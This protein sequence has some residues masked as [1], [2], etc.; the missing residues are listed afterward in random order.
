MLAALDRFFFR[1]VRATPLAL[2]RIGVGFLTFVWAV[3]LLPDI[4]PLLTAMRA[5]PEGDV[6]WWQLWPQ[7]PPAVTLA[8]GL[9]LI[10]SAGLLTVGLWTRAAAWTAFITCLALQ[11]Y[12]PAAFNGGDWILRCVLLP[13]LALAPAGAYLS[14]DR[15]RREGRWNWEAPLVV[16]WA[17][18]FVQL[19][20]S[21]GYILTVV[22]KLRGHSWPGGTALWNA[23]NLADL[24]RFEVPYWIIAPPVGAVLT[25]L[26]LTFELGVGVGV[27]FRRLRPWALLGGVALHLGIA[28]TM[29]ITL[30]SFIMIS[31][32]LAFLPAVDDVRRLLLFRRLVPAKAGAA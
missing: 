28:A 3:F 11:R 5:S 2:L 27:W 30:F 4:N 31:S 12:N 20:I 22:L 9:L 10:L 16:P 21:L 19:H 26:V 1:P 6:N 13:G 25:W 29:E 8:M 7:A 15:L 14:V 23:L 32:Y 24:T 18:R 17:L